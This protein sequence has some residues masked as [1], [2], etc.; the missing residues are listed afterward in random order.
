MPAGYTSGRETVLRIDHL[1]VFFIK[2]RLLERGTIVKAVDG[3]SLDVGRGEILALVG[4]SGSGKTTLGRAVIGLVRP[5]GGTI[6]LTDGGEPEDVGNAKGARWKKLRRKLQM[7]FQDPFASIDPN[8]RVYDALR[9][10][11]GPRASGRRRRWP[12]G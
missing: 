9:T 6:T 10:R 11:S 1:A 3:V 4:E 7:I 8:M 5:T 12:L 2:K